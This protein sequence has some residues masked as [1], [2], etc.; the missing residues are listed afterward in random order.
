[1]KNI[2][3]ETKF[4]KKCGEEKLLIEFSKDKRSRDERTSYCKKCVNIYG[5]KWKESHRE[6]VKENKKNWYKANLEKEKEKSRIWDINNPEKVKEKARRW[7]EE[8]PLYF[9]LALKKQG[10]PEER[11]TPEL[12]ELKRMIIKTKRKIKDECKYN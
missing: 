10:F 7:K 8:N 2:S 9:K 11:I 5:E 1:M 6:Q 4:C 3:M 12:M